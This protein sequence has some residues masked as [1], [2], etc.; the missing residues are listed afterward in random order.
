MV[1]VG[2]GGIDTVSHNKINKYTTEYPLVKPHTSICRTP[3]ITPDDS[4]SDDGKVQLTQEQVNQNLLQQIRDLQENQE[5]LNAEFSARTAI[6]LEKIAS[7]PIDLSENEKSFVPCH[8]ALSPMST[9]DRNKIIRKFKRINGLPESLH[10]KNGLATIGIT[11]N[12]SKNFIT[13]VYPNMQKNGLDILRMSLALHH[14]ISQDGAMSKD[15]LCEAL[16]SIAQ[17]AADNVQILAQKQTAM[18]LEARGVKGAE[19]LITEMDINLSDN[20]IIQSCHVAA[21][22]ELKKFQAAVVP[23]KT[24]SSSSSF[25]K[26]SNP[27]SSFKAPTKT[28]GYKGKNY[29]PNYQK[30]NTS[31]TNTKP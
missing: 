6:L 19:A 28:S 5:K 10:D 3:R 7:E 16:Q 23:K 25:N 30:T 14:Q 8:L 22:T 31:S 21:I 29:N 26:S 12:K 15:D 2:G 18:S 4:M 24:S 17:I 13:N 20:N 11:D 27:K 9:A 1:E